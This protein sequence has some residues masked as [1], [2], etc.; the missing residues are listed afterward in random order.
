MSYKPRPLSALWLDDDCPAGVLAIY[1]NPAYADRYTVFY[2]DLQEYPER[3]QTGL[4]GWLGYRGM[5]ENPFHPQ[6]VGMY[7]EM[8]AYQASEYRRANGHRKC[9][10]SDL[11]EKVKECVRRDLVAEIEVAA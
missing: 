3:G 8:R 6:G 1:D 7:G 4:G 10:W 2:S 5:S 11:P 9:K